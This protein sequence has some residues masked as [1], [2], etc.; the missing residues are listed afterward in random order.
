MRWQDD[1]PD[2]SVSARAVSTVHRLLVSRRA[3]Q[4]AWQVISFL[5]MVVFGILCGLIG[6]TIQAKVEDLKKGKSS[7]LEEDHSVG[8]CRGQRAVL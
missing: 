7:V 5:G 2:E 6:E 8:C 4:L 1:S 3:A